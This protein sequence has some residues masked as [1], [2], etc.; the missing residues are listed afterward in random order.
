MGL[1]LLKELACCVLLAV[2]LVV[3]IG[4]GVLAWKATGKLVGGV[5]YA[6]TRLAQRRWSEVLVPGRRHAILTL[7]PVL[8]SARAGGESDLASKIA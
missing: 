2:A 7:V 5:R 3:L 1:Y 4:A 8:Q 6:H